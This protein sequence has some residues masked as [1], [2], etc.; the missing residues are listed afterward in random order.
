MCLCKGCGATVRSTVS[1]WHKYTFFVVGSDPMASVESVLAAA[2]ADASSANTTLVDD[3]KR[4]QIDLNKQ[5]ASLKKEL[6]NAQR[7]E[8]RLKRKAGAALS[9]ADLVELLFRKIQ[10]ESTSN[11][12][13]GSSVAQGSASSGASGSSVAQDAAGSGDASGS[14]VAQDDATALA[15]GGGV[16]D[17]AL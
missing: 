5:R 3:L 1:S 2:A 9:R 17:D 16:E 8:S 6:K 11:D 14:S 4:R 13:S 7:R 15:G 10:K 12:A